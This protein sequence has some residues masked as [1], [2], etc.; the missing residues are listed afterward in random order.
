VPAFD[1]GNLRTTP[2][3]EFLAYCSKMP[4]QEAAAILRK[5]YEDTGIRLPFSLTVANQQPDASADIITA[6]PTLIGG[7]DNAGVM[8]PILVNPV[9][10]PIVAVQTIDDGGVGR[11]VISDRAGILAVAPP[12]SKLWVAVGNATGAGS[13]VATQAAPGAGLRNVVLSWGLSV[14]CAA[15]ALAPGFAS[16]TGG[17]FGV[18][19]AI[20]CPANDSRNLTADGPYLGAANTAVALSAPAIG[21]GAV[22]AV[23]LCGYTAAFP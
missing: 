2:L 15:A 4:I 19:Q 8:R 16:L 23:W 11:T 13:A 17:S 12:V 7:R 20:A 1:L 3:G 6:N 9:G 18:S 5:L 22:S 10:N 21:A 14:A